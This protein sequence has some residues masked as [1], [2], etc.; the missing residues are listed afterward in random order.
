MSLRA[1]TACNCSSLIWPRWLR[2][3]RFSEP[4]CRLLRGHKQTIGKTEWIATFLPFSRACIFFLLTLSSLW[5]FLFLSSSLWLFPPLLFQL[6]LLSEVSPL[7]FLR[8]SPY[9]IP[10]YLHTV[11]GCELLHRLKT[12]V[13]PIIYRV[14]TIQGDLSSSMTYTNGR[15]TSIPRGLFLRGVSLRQDGVNGLWTEKEMTVEAIVDTDGSDQMLLWFGTGDLLGYTIYIYI[16]L[17][18]Y[19]YIYISTYNIYIYTQYIYIY[20]QYIYIYLQY[21]YIYTYNIYIYINTYNIYIYKY[22]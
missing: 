15:S 14:S 17:Y 6:S 2:T 18:I 1:T 13:Y 20:T 8:W 19:I 10:R 7:N 5:S 11:D 21:I 4:T 12:V 22:L 3:S 16:Y 9:D